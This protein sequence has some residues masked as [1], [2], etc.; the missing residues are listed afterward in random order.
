MMTRPPTDGEP[1]TVYGLF[2]TVMR[3]VQSI[4]KTQQNKQQGYNFR[5]IDAVFDTVGPVIREAG[6]IVLPETVEVLTEERYLT[7]NDANMR[8][9]TVRVTWRIVGPNGDEM[10]AQSL[11]EAADSGD[12]AVSKA[13]SVAGR[14]LWL[15]GLWV[16]TGERDPDEDNHERARPPAR[17]RAQ[18]QQPAVDERTPLRRE[19]ATLGKALGRPAE[20]L[21]NEFAA[22]HGGV[23]P[24]SASVE[25]LRTF[26]AGLRGEAKTR[27]ESG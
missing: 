16:P 26:L 18:R 9:V 6:L 3:A 22:L 5:G 2:V 14:T 11:G 12:K 24:S 27:V 17:P 1:L 13:Q 25:Q 7:K 8:N 23:M 10:R 19:I 21:Q 15:L 20:D 4:A